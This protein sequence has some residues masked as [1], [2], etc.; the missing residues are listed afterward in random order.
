MEQV[1]GSLILFCLCIIGCDG[2]F[3]FF[4]LYLKTCFFIAFFREKGRERN[5]DM[6]ETVHPDGWSNLQLRH[7][8]WPGIEPTTFLLRDDA[9]TNWAIW[10]R[11]MTVNFL[12]QL[13]WAMGCPNVW[14]NII[15]GVS[16]RV[17]LDEINVW[18]GRPQKA[19]C[20]PSCGW[21]SSN[22]LKTRIEQKSWSSHQ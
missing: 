22:Q 9:P 20:P 12:C 18:I 8:P 21:A 15:L 19:N 6:R 5:I 4:N 14:I 11:A 3:F 7:V 13:D 16:M 17:F 2:S 10:A 1:W